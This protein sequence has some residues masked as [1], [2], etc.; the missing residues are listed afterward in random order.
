MRAGNL[1]TPAKAMPSS[2]TS[3]SGSTCPLPC[4]R[5]RNSSWIASASS[6]G[7]PITRS[8]ITEAEACEIEH[9]SAS[10]DTSAT[11]PSATWTRSV[12]SSPQVGLT[13]CTSASYGS[14]SPW[15]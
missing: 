15:W 6:T 12:T 10:Y 1:A 4:I 8:V 7:L 5:A 3:S 11:R 14:R 13:W 2:S 9:P